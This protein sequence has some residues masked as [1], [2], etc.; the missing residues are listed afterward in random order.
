MS[1]KIP[2]IKDWNK[3]VSQ[4]NNVINEWLYDDVHRDIVRSRMLKGEDFETISNRH[5]LSYERVRDIYYEERK[6]VF[7]HKDD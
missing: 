6:Q 3:S 1:N 4:L 7:K 5:N 2:P